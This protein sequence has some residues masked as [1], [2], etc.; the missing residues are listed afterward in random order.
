MLLGYSSPLTPNSF[1]AIG[2]SVMTTITDVVAR[3]ILDSRGNPTV[4][5]DVY[6][7]D[8]SHGRAAVP[9]GASTGAH[10]AVELRDDDVSRHMGKGVLTAVENVNDRIGP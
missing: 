10:E 5:G 9:S 1:L 7:E 2:A 3:E 8:G 4:E 6:L